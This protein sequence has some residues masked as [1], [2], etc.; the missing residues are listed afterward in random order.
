MPP[1]ARTRPSESWAGLGDATA[2]GAGPGGGGEMTSATLPHVEVTEPR[3]TVSWEGPGEPIVLTVG[4]VST[5]LTPTRALALAVEL[6]QRAVLT[7]PD[8]L[9]HDPWRI[10]RFNKKT[11]F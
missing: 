7:I 11:C 8:R 2:P 5:P 10:D 9:A 6:T 3:A 4:E 1:E